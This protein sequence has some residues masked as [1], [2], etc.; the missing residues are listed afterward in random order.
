MGKPVKVTSAPMRVAFF[1]I[2]GN[3]PEIVRVGDRV[4]L[5]SV[6]TAARTC[7]LRMFRFKESLRRLQLW[8]VLGR[9]TEP[10]KG[11][12]IIHMKAPPGW[13]IDY[14]G[15]NRDEVASEQGPP[16]LDTPENT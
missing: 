16:T 10:E 12:L 8:G 15:P 7:Q 9:I 4:F 13:K 2:W 5:E 1:L 6:P 14:K 11:Q 3:H